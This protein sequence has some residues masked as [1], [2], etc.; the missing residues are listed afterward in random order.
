MRNFWGSD[1]PPPGPGRDAGMLSKGAGHYL[2]TAWV[3]ASVARIHPKTAGSRIH[4]GPLAVLL[5]AAP[6][7]RQWHIFPG[8]LF[9]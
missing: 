8:Y 7:K 2:L 9:S 6:P 1:F 4:A 3:R 5:Y